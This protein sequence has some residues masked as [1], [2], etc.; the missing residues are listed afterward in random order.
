MQV[1]L[2]QLAEKVTQESP[3]VVTLP[4]AA[5][6]RNRAIPNPSI[7]ILNT[8]SAD[9]TLETSRVKWLEFLNKVEAINGID[10]AIVVQARQLALS[11]HAIY[12]TTELNRRGSLFKNRIE[13]AAKAIVREDLTVTSPQVE[14]AK[15]LIKNPTEL[16]DLVS[17]GDNNLIRSLLDLVDRGE[18]GEAF[19]QLLSSSLASKKSINSF[20]LQARV[21]ETLRMLGT[22]RAKALKIQRHQAAYQLLQLEDQISETYSTTFLPLAEKMGHEQAALL[23]LRR[24]TGV[25]KITPEQWSVVTG[26]AAGGQFANIFSQALKDVSH[27]PVKS[28]KRKQSAV[29]LGA[30]LD[31][32]FGEPGPSKRARSRGANSPSIVEHI[33]R[34]VVDTQSSGGHKPHYNQHRGGRGGRGGTGRPTF[35]GGRGNASDK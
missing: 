9:P 3:S 2:A 24:G 8:A 5:K 11:S 23:W 30:T 26:L 21:L 13:K 12:L 19:T 16:A 18:S 7:D 32:D 34:V 28:E 31:Q 4:C 1:D 25:S 33:V 10:P 14:Q 6:P 20:Q 22:T 17:E 29:E 27:T 35:Q 15:D